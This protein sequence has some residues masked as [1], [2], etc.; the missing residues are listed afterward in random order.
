MKHLNRDLKPHAEEQYP[1]RGPFL[2]GEGFAAKA[3]ATADGTRALKGAQKSFFGSGDSKPLGRR[4]QLGISSIPSQSHRGVFRCL[5]PPADPPNG[6]RRTSTKISN[7]RIKDSLVDIP[8]R[9]PV[10]SD[11]QLPP[12]VM[13]STLAGRTALH[14]AAWQKLT[15]DQWVLEAISGNKIELIP[16]PCQAHQPPT[17]EKGERATAISKELTNLL[18]KGAVQEVQHQVEPGFVS[19]LF[20]V[21]KKGGQMRPVI[22]LRPFNHFVAFHHFKMEGIQVVKD[23]LQPND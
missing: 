8:Q 17:L 15:S 16:H 13:V 4:K 22:N 5:G 11:L 1:S 19:R 7:P 21:P 23:I 14:K 6:P 12:P 2:F 18:E 3:K 9:T 20:L 10:L